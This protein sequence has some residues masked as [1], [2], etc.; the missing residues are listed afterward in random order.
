M[1]KYKICLILLL[2]FSLQGRTQ[3]IPHQRLDFECS[4][5]HTEE[6]WK[7]IHFDH[8]QTH[9]PLQHKHRHLSCHLCHD[10]KDFGS[11][12][13]ICVDC[14]LDVHQSRLGVNCD[15]CHDEQGWQILSPQ[16]AHASTAFPLLGAHARLD[17]KVCHR[18]EIQGEFAVLE[19]DCSTCHSGLYEE[20][21]NPNHAVMGFSRRCEQCH[22][23]FSWTPANFGDH[24]AFFPINSGAHADVWKDCTTCHYLQN[25]YNEF[26]CFQNCHEHNKNS[27]DSHHREVGG[28]SYDSQRCLSCHP[29]GSGGD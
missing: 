18:G 20:T 12:R 27:M 8:D 14:H 15:R 29:R 7:K 2:G 10:I 17:C 6:E 26:S 1:I 25:N 22:S 9:F 3:Q 21:K 5:C 23:F 13:A 11:T 19:S 28:Y 4:S 16:K 24:N